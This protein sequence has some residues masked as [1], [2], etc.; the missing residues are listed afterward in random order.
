MNNE[1]TNTLLNDLQTNYNTE[2]LTNKD[3]YT[4]I[5]NK[6]WLILIGILVIL[7]L[8]YIYYSDIRLTIPL[9]SNLFNMSNLKKYNK[10]KQQ[11][12]NKNEKEDYDTDSESECDDEINSDNDDWDLE[13][14]IKNYMN[15]Q[16]EYIANIK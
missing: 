12:N 11:K 14:E 3:Y 16:H 4:I 6:K 1:L 9:I 13:N 8:F 5:Y 15:K 10:K 7:L 2:N